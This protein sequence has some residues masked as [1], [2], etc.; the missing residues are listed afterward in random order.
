M[1]LGCSSSRQTTTL[2]P[3]RQGNAAAMMLSPSEMFLVMAISSARALISRAK[4]SRARS[5]VAN[6]A[7]LSAVPI[8]TL[9]REAVMAACAERGSRPRAAVSR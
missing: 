8:S 5:T 3:A 4:R 9:S 2:S 7:T 1:L 6:I